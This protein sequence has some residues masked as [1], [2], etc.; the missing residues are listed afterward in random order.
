MKNFKFFG[1]SFLLL[2][3]ISTGEDWN[4]I[5]YDTMKTRP[6]CIEV[7]DDETGNCGSL[8]APIF[9]LVFNLLVSQV[10]LNLFILVILQQFEKYYI[11][12][13]GP[14]KRFKADLTIFVEHWCL[15]TEKYDC[16]MIKENSQ[17]K[18]FFEK[19]P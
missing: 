4:R 18:A 2:F 19:L 15:A 16:M 12:E 13:N 8:Y 17:F 9:F 11:D 7:N 14:L 3:S 5:M 10:M 1:S 6:Y